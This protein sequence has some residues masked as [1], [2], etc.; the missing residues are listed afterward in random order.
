MSSTNWSAIFE[1]YLIPNT[2][3]IEAEDISKQVSNEVRSS[4]GGAKPSTDTSPTGAD[5]AEDEEDL[6]KVDDIFGTE[7]AQRKQGAD[8]PSGDPNEAEDGSGEDQS[9]NPPDDGGMGDSE[10]GGEDLEDGGDDG[11]GEAPNDPNVDPNG[12]GGGGEG[13]SGL[14]ESVDPNL[15][16]AEKNRIRDN[17]VQLYAICNGDIES[18]VSSL[19]SVE[20][21]KTIQVLNAVLNHLRN[22]KDYTYKTL[23]T[24]LQT[25][26]YDELL[27][28]YITLKRVYD[29]CGEMLKEH[30][31]SDGNKKLDI[32]SKKPTETGSKI[33]G[34]DRIE[35][36]G[37]NKNMGV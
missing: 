17:L 6:G 1:S 37:A 26:S 5:G 33:P 11:T 22:C 8:G 2:P 18:I 36:F 21:T 34:K 4:L 7:E 27:Q 25:K 35:I 29:I 30:F 3:A 14:D 24:N 20:D 13:D 12:E 28:R 16:F 31:K 32:K 23:T 15:A 9:L 19:N 10:T